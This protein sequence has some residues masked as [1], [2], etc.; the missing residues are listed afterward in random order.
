MNSKIQ[1]PN[2]KCKPLSWCLVFETYERSSLYQSTHKK[3][4][5]K[6]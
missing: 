6:I 1:I 4:C 2:L 3:D 5:E